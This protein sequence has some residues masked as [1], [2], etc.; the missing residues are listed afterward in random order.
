MPRKRTREDFIER[1]RAIHG[2]KYDYS[3]IKVLS[4]QMNAIFFVT[5]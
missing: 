5:L 2:D 3:N 4:I 1:A